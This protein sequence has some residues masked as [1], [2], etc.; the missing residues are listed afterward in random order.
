MCVCVCVKKSVQ[1]TMYRLLLCHCTFA[2]HDFGTPRHTAFVQF[3][4]VTRKYQTDKRFSSGRLR[5]YGEDFNNYPH[6]CIVVN[7]HVWVT[8]IRKKM[9]PPVRLLILLCK[10]PHVAR[11]RAGVNKRMDEQIIFRT[12]ARFI[13]LKVTVIRFPDDR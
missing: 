8:Q 1:T 2:E 5:V 11:N 12:F 6:V 7:V 13:L 10:T 4:I 3:A 9:C